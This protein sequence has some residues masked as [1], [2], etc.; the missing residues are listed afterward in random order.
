MRR[1]GADKYRT[2][3]GLLR[4]VVA[5]MARPE[6]DATLLADAGRW[7]HDTQMDAH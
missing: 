4:F 7:S 5:E 6:A 3:T 1:I 2:E